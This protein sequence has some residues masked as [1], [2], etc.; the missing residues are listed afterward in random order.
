MAELDHSQG[1]ANDTDQ[2]DFVVEVLGSAVRR[3]RHLLAQVG[4]ERVTASFR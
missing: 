3:L 2:V 4:C 1:I